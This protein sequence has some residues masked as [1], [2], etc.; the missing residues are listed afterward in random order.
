M[1][2]VACLLVFVIG[3]TSLDVG[4]AG[5]AVNSTLSTVTGTLKGLP[6]DGVLGLLQLLLAVVLALLGGLP[7]V[8][9][10]VKSLDIEK[11]V[12]GLT[13]AVGGGGGDSGN[14]TST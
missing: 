10:V 1:L 11:V 2:L 7:V 8:G 9:D 4:G 6:I 5:D 3:A 13:G 14:S 12:S